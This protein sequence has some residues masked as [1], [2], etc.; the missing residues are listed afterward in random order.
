[1]SV[2]LKRT[3]K[4][5]TGNV[6]G[7][8]KSRIPWCTHT[9]SPVEGCTKVS[10]GCDNCYGERILRRW[11]RPTTPVIHEERFHAPEYRKKRAVVFVCPMADL[12]SLEVPAADIERIYR[13]MAACPQHAFLVL[14]KRTAS[15]RAFFAASDWYY[16]EFTLGH[17]SHIAVG[18]SAVLSS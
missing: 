12:F 9:W 3:R 18:I 4:G 15:M 14:T 13:V 16:R 2:A 6:S 10:P 1:M 11:G 17:L 7:M 5:L 8:S